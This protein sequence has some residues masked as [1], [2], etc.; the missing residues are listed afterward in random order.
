M[1]TDALYNFPLSSAQTEYFRGLLAQSSHYQTTASPS[2][3]AVLLA[4]A[5]HEDLIAAGNKGYIQLHSKYNEIKAESLLLCEEIVHLRNFTNT[6]LSSAWPLGP[7]QHGSSP[8]QYLKRTASDT[9]RLS[10]QKLPDTKD[11]EDNPDVPWWDEA[12]WKR[13]IERKKK[14]G[15]N[16][17]R[18]AFLTDDDGSDISAER[19]K[20][21]TET[22]KTLWN[23]H[24][25]HN[26]PMNPAMWKK[27]TSKTKEYF[28]FHMLTEYSKFLLA[29]N[30]WKLERFTTIRYPDWTAAMQKS[31]GNS[32]RKGEGTDLRPQ[33]RRCSPSKSPQPEAKMVENDLKDVHAPSIPAIPM[34][35][36]P[37]V[38]LTASSAPSTSSPPFTVALSEP[39]STPFFAPPGPQAMFFSAPSSLTGHA[40]KSSD[41][42]LQQPRR[43]PNPLINLEIP[44]P[45][46]SVPEE[47]VPTS[48]P[49][50]SAKAKKPKSKPL[51]PKED[52]TEAKFSSVWKNRDK[53]TK[54]KYDSLE[55][56]AKKA[57]S[58]P[59]VT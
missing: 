48:Q 13:H 6:L 30:Y 28:Y 14:R 36:S 21:M 56:A 17:D 49:A 12:K 20:Q 38:S 1:S 55:K 42:R 3:E 43:I 26:P 58:A 53:E 24:L 59:A 27:K 25:A 44:R 2:P 7:S 9:L 35:S 50:A 40:A 47:T 45:T 8:N 22:A 15:E 51:Q 32:K 33:K 54:K 37:T 29:N 16:I 31:G 5:T 18:L 19:L 4:T 23:E 39:T 57:S 34:A 10:K 41:T 52:A 46:V 11:K